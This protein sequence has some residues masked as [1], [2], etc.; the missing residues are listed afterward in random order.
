M[1]MG[2]ELTTVSQSVSQLVIGEV[3]LVTRGAIGIIGCRRD[4]MN[5]S[6]HTPLILS[7]INLRTYTEKK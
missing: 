4:Y 5:L 3:R 6:K 2:S 1:L 7:Y